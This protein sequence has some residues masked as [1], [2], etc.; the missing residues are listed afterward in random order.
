MT[1][2]VLVDLAVGQSIGS[3]TLE[4]DRSRLVRYAGSSRDFNPIHWNDRFALE[5]GLPGFLFRSTG[6]SPFGPEFSP[7]ADHQRFLV[8]GE[9]QKPNALLDLVVNWPLQVRGGK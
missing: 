1:A 5:V 7:T 9:G 3:C 8:V 6:P 4:V 2:P